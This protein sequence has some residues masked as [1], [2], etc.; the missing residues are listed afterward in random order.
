MLS[1]IQSHR[2][3]LAALCERVGARRL[4]AFGSAVRSDFDPATSDLNFI[5]EFEPLAPAGYAEAYFT[6][7]GE[8][9]AMFGRRVDLLTE[10]SLDNPF[11]RRRVD[12]E[13]HR[14]Y[15]R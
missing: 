2:M 12:A 1:T 7:K 8:L 9:E 10:R 4:D 13:R 14:I 6:L 15:A 11:L 3:E 5:V